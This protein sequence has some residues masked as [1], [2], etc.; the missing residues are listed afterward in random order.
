MRLETNC[1]VVSNIHIDPISDRSIPGAVTGR[2]F[3]SIEQSIMGDIDLLTSGELIALYKVKPLYIFHEWKIAFDLLKENG[4]ASLTEEFETVAYMH[5]TDDVVK[6]Y[7][8]IDADKL[9]IGEHFIGQVSYTEL[10][11]NVSQLERD[12]K[13]QFGNVA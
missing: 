8:H 7:W 10:V 4:T 3:F 1:I 13:D 2:K 12:I 9:G 6:F 5:K 11:N